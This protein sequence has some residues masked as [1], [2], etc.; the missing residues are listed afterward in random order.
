MAPV[1]TEGWIFTKLCLVLSDELSWA[2]KMTIFP[3]KWRAIEN[4]VE[5]WAPTSYDVDV[6]NL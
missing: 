4:K 6:K 3:T 5:G 1:S 2:A